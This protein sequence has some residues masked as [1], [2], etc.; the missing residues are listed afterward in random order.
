MKKRYPRLEISLEKIRYNT[1]TV[2]KV[3]RSH[4]IGVTGVTK[5][6]CGNVEIARAM[7]EGG[8]EMLGDSR[9]E[10]LKGLQDIRLPKMLLRLPM[11]SQVREVVRYADVSLDSELTTLKA[12]S[13]AALEQGRRHKVILMIDLGDLREGIFDP[14][15]LYQV[16]DGSLKL[17]AIELWG[18]GTNLTC[19]GG[20]IPTP[21][22]LS[23]LIKLTQTIRAEFGIELM[24]I[25]GGN[26]S[27]FHL[28]EKGLLPLGINQLR[29]GEAILCGTEAAYGKRIVDTYGDSFRL[30]SEIIEIKQKPSTPIGTIG[31]DAFGRTP[32]FMDRGVRKK[33][34]C[35]VGKQDIELE[36]LS[37]E[38]GKITILG[39]S[40]DHLVLDI[41]DSA[42]NYQLGDVIPFRVHYAGILRCMSSKYIHK[43]FLRS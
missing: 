30:L 2:V 41:T 26:S 13:Q 15:E 38:D 20:V 31:R 28:L 3:C 9:L 6:V 16:V 8:A 33:A 22:N 21:E 32:S 37:P 18:I 4:G 40:G 12:L 7:A 25:S 24:T 27:S 35:A 5:G 14:D 42:R 36:S 34:I 17:A 39:A 29:L 19:F 1:E 11:I 10:N 23:R 43:E